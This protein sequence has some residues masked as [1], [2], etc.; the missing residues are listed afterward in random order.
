MTTEETGTQETFDQW[1]SRIQ[2]L[3]VTAY[4]N[5]QPLATL[6]RISR[7]PEGQADIKPLDP[8]TA[9]AIEQALLSVGIVSSNG[10]TF[11]AVP[12]RS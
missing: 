7:T 11:R 5:T 2:E 6:A 3:E 1:F 9:K 12:R 8:G 4:G 10:H